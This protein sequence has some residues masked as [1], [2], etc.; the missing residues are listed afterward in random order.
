MH[1]GK[2]ERR[3]DDPDL[4]SEP[5][6]AGKWST[7]ERSMRHARALDFITDADPLEELCFLVVE[8]REFPPSDT[9]ESTRGSREVDEAVK[10]RDHVPVKPGSFSKC[11]SDVL[12]AAWNEECVSLT[13]EVVVGDMPTSRAGTQ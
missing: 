13:V 2:E 12:R 4:A 3:A 6:R 8:C 7:K 10:Q 11:C 5:V 9:L 1:G